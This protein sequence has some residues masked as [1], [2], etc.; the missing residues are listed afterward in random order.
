M[1]N[2]SLSD[3]AA[4]TRNVDGDGWGAGGGW[5]MIILFA[6]IFG[7]NG[8]WGNNNRGNAVTEADLC[9]ANS[10][11]ELKNSVGRL[12]DQV[13]DMNVGFTKG[14]CDFGYTTLTQ[15][16]ALEK[17]LSDCCCQTQNAIQGV[18]YDMATQACDTRNT[19]QNSTRDIIDNQNANY[20]GLMD[21]MVQ[22]KIDSLQSENQ[23]LK[24]AASQASQNS[25]LTST[26]DAQTS[27]LIRRINPMP[28]PAYQV[29]APYPFC[30]TGNG[31]GCGC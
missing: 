1:D 5:I 3:I 28:V 11:S 7:G 27:E 10:F 23:A 17:Q 14:L 29:P 15:F 12:S 19:I 9:N 20:R 8:L 21:F 25:Y 26:L 6:L 2:M 22:S 13:G 4:V 18:R 24:L 31:C 30:G 16:N